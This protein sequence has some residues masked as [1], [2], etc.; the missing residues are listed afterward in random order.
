MDLKF[1]FWL[2]SDVNYFYEDIKIII[3][4]IFPF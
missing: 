4:V 2:N 1:D 3:L